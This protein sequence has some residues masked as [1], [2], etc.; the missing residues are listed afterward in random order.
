MEKKLT[1]AKVKN[2][3]PFEEN[4]IIEGNPYHF[5]IFNSKGEKIGRIYRT[6]VGKF[7]HWALFPD[8]CDGHDLFFT[9]GC[10]KEISEFITK[11]YSEKE[12]KTCATK[13]VIPPK[14]K[15]SGIL[16]NFT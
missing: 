12:G 13:H 11:C 9:N 4:E 16:P 3:N 7:M 2:I 5:E 15:D 1:F 10:L 6:R 14:S 8:K